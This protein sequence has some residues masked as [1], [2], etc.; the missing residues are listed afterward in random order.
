MELVVLCA[1][2]TS[3]TTL[4]TPMMMPSIVRN[5]RILLASVERTASR[6]SLKTSSCDTRLLQCVVKPPVAHVYR[7]LRLPCHL[8][9]VRNQHDGVCWSESFGSGA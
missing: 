5:E 8:V 3:T 1:I 6:R 9:V 7:A 2:E 4:I